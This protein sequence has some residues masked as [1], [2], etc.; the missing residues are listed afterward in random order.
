MRLEI[1][2]GFTMV[3]LITVI[4]IIGILAGVLLP[5]LSKGR[6]KALQSSC[7]SNLRNIGEAL[8]IYVYENN[9]CLPSCAWRLGDNPDNLPYIHDVLFPY[10]KVKEIFRCPADTLYY[11]EEGTSYEW[12][13]Y[14]NGYH[15]DAQPDFQTAPYFSRNEVPLIFDIDN[16]HIEN[17]NILFPDAR[18]DKTM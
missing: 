4:A 13:Q 6:Q 5:T 1:T 17:K 15:Y 10:L 16:F 18:V 8:E 14:V 12:N 9:M 7:M 3:E 11:T 2:R